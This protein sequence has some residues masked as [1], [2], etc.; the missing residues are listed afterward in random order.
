[1]G[2]FNTIWQGD[3]NAMTLC[4][5][6]HAAIPPRIFNVTGPE[7]LSVRVVCERFGQLFNKLPRFT[8]TESDTALLNN[9]NATIATLGPLRVDA[10]ELID[11][12][13]NWVKAGG[14]QL[15][16]PTHFEVRDGRF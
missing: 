15:G 4:A 14:R 1:M 7:V 2:Y 10:N 3:A 5:L 9:A 16:K 8:G 11:W 12:V 13:A 6:D